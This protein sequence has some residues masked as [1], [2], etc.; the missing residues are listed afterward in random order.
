MAG[1]GTFRHLLGDLFGQAPPI[2]QV[3]LL[4][5]EIDIGP[6]RSGLDLAACH[7]PFFR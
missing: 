1:K 7:R 2:G 4:G 3:D 6:D 5:I